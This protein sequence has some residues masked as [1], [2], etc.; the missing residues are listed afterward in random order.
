[1][2]TSVCIVSPTKPEEKTMSRFKRLSHMIWHCEYHILGVL[3]YRNRV[4]QGKIKEEMD[5][6]VREQTRQMN[7]ELQ[8][9]NVQVDHVHLIGQIPPRLSISDDMGRLN[10]KSAIRVFSGYR[11]LRQ[12]R[13]RGNHFWAQGDCV[14]TVG[15]NG[16]ITRKQLKWQWKK[17]QSQEQLRFGNYMRNRRRCVR[18][19]PFGGRHD[20]VTVFQS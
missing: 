11:D 20:V 2:T 18:P 3:K 4:I 6:C 15:L 14:G 9:L 13:Y 19:A 5:R 12:R 10:G 17:E 8:E 16:E 7:C 1:M